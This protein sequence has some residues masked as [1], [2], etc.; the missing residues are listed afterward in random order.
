MEFRCRLGTPGGEIIEGVYVAESEARLRR[1]FEE[2]GLY[3][4]GIQRGLCRL[5]L[6]LASSK[7]SHVRVHPDR[8]LHAGVTGV[9]VQRVSSPV[10][11]TVSKTLRPNARNTSTRATAATSADQR[12]IA[13]RS[14]SATGPSMTS[15]TTSGTPCSGP[16]GLP[17]RRAYRTTAA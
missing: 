16:S 7:A 1:E 6:S 13:S 14:P 8:L 17:C 2:K 15:F 11:R 10:E 9:H 5:H 4:L 3:V 12:T